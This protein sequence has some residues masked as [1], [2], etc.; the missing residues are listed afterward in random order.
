MKMFIQ[1]VTVNIIWHLEQKK[2]LE[3]DKT[4]GTSKWLYIFSVEMES[5]LQNSHVE[6]PLFV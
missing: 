5:T 2:G 6:F 3:P 4:F 1:P